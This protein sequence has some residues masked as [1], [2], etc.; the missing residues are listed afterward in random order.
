MFSSSHSILLDTKLKR[1]VWRVL[2]E[3]FELIVKPN[4]VGVS[5]PSGTAVLWQRTQLTKRE[6]LILCEV[7]IKPVLCLPDNN[8][9]DNNWA[10]RRQ[11]MENLDQPW[12][13]LYQG[14][15][16]SWFMVSMKSR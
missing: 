14:S 13:Q 2:N 9:K 5:S 7:K 10:Q 15:R 11:M 1:P 6:S 4:Y 8:R 3:D 12:H 16:N